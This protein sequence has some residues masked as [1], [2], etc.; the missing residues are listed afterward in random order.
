MHICIYEDRNYR[1]LLPLVYFRPVYDLRCGITL[2]REKI[3]RCFTDANVILHTRDYLTETVQRANPESPV[4]CI[5][6]GVE[7]VLFVNG[8]VLPGPEFEKLIGAGQSDRVFMTGENVVAAWLSGTELRKMN[9]ILSRRVLADSDFLHLERKPIGAQ[10][11]TFPWELIHYNGEWIKR[12]FNFFVNGL[13][14]NDLSNYPG[15]YFNRPERIHISKEVTIKPGVVLDAE[16]GPIYLGTGVKILPNA[17]I[18]GSVY[19]GNG[20]LIKAGAKIYENTSIG[21]VCKV[22]GEVEE[23]IIHGYSNKQHEGFLGHAYLGAWVNIGADTNNSDLK[24]DYGTVKVFIDGELVDSGSQ[25]VG[26]IMGDHSKSGINTMF[27]TGTVIGVSCN[28]FGAGFQAKFIPS[29]SWGGPESLTTYR[30]EKA[31]EVARRVMERRGIPFSDLDRKIFRTVFD[32]TS[33]ERRRA[34]EI[35]RF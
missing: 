31:Q 32:D 4:N 14:D 23:S 3:L 25:F 16:D 2:L 17:V 15:V 19:I 1:K 29:F 9:E 22:G 11:I 28:I 20:S 7:R 34:D 27:N 21:P 35:T 12:D 13:S 8:R 10:L 18:E 24:N 5:P 26:L 33:E 30:L 6:T